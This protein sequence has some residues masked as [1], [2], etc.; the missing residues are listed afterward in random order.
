MLGSWGFEK[1]VRQH[2][3]HPAI[4]VVKKRKREGKDTE[5]A[6][7]DKKITAERVKKRMRRPDVKLGHVVSGLSLSDMT[8]KSASIVASTPPSTYFAGPQEI[9]SL[10]IPFD[11]GAQFLELNLPFSLAWNFII[12]TCK[13]C[14]R[15]SYISRQLTLSAVVDRNV[16]PHDDGL[17]LRGE[18][19]REVIVESVRALGYLV[20]IRTD[21]LHLPSSLL[22]SFLDQERSFGLHRQQQKSMQTHPLLYLF[23]TLLYLVS[24]NL[25]PQEHVDTIVDWLDS[26]KYLYALQQM[27]GIH[28]PSVEEFSARLLLSAIKLNKRNVA[29]VLLDAGLSVQDSYRQSPSFASAL[30]VALDKR[31]WAM[32]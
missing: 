12:P 8:Q 15:I 26:S 27:A 3:W 25:L 5:L 16:S 18:S 9:Y 22:G 4:S 13:V 14:P 2:E 24:N 11:G 10:S 29:G 7:G 21:T 28:T 30:S 23:Q 19:L 31:R 32:V 20:K 17:I 1:N 6:I